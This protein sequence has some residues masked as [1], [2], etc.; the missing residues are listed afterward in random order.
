MRKLF[1]FPR[2]S[3]IVW[4]K[5]SVKVVSTF[6]YSRTGSWTLMTSTV[7]AHHVALRDDSAW[8]TRHV[9]QSE[10]WPASFRSITAAVM[11]NLSSD[12][13]RLGNLNVSLTSDLSRT[14]GTTERIR[15][16]EHLVGV[17]QMSNPRQNHPSINLPRQTHLHP[18][19]GLNF[20]DSKRN[21]GICT[22]CL[23]LSMSDCGI[24]AC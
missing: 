10:T 7:T 9:Q 18:Y 13:G 12:A 5:P 22:F 14:S 3:C 16:A 4:P 6:M 24:L 20:P 1:V 19:I 23:C 8:R 17:N 11:Y 2:C 15:A 21:V